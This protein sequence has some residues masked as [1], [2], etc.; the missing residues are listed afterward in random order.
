MKTNPP[1][2]T[3]TQAGL[4]ASLFAFC[5]IVLLAGCGQPPD[6]RTA[7]IAAATP[8]EFTAW[9]NAASQ[10]IPAD[11]MQEFDSC[12]SEI[13]MGIM[14]RKEASGAGPIAQKLCEHIQGKTMRE[15]IAM[16]H[17]ATVAWVTRELALQRTNIAKTEAAL[18]GPG[19]DSKKQELRDYLAI[20]KDN[21]AKLEAR[22]EKARARLAELGAD[23]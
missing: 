16:G 11:E 5:A 15:V 4:V 10:K 22:L 1:T 3:I 13:R 7:P 8:E 9:K 6:P 18:S 20:A 14:Q 2:R 17:N 23:S 19:S 21:V 12:V